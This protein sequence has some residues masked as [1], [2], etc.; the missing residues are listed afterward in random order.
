M[1][2]P[3]GV[4]PTFTLTFSDEALDLTAAS[5]V[6]VTFVGGK[7][8]TKSDSELTIEEKQISVYLSQEETLSFNT[9]LV[10]I[11]VNWTYG[12]GS[13]SASEMV[14]YPFSNNLLNEVVQ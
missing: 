1:S 7:T 11:Q 9:G 12:N 5:H 14:N 6:Y 2:I 8:V 4:T 13:R 3:R 10:S